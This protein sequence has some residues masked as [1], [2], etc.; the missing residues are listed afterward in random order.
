MFFEMKLV[1][2]D[3]AKAVP[4]GWFKYFESSLPIPLSVLYRPAPGF[5]LSADK[6]LD[7]EN[8]YIVLENFLS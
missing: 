6:D 4:A 1:R 7:L 5:R 8:E 3:L 2:F